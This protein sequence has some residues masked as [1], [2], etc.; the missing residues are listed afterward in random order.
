MEAPAPL[1]DVVGGAHER[2][3]HEVHALLDAEPEIVHVLLG[4]AGRGQI[5]VRQRDALVVADP[6]ACDDDAA[7][8]LR[9]RRLHAE[10]D[11]AVV[12]PDL[13]AGPDT[14]E[15]LGRRDE[16]A[17]GGADARRAAEGE[18]AP[19]VWTYPPASALAEGP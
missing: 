16:H 13:V 7:N 11:H 17:L 8:L 1:A 6:A 3:G 4:E 14:S 9:R 19:G 10:L 2:H 12:H 5:R 15:V 18:R